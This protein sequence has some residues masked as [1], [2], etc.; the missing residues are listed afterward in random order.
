MTVPPLTT[1]T[2]T[3]TT[4]T[5]L[6]PENVQLDIAVTS[7]STVEVT[8]TSNPAEDILYYC[9]SFQGD[10]LKDEYTVFD[11]CTINGSKTISKSFQFEQDGLSAGTVYSAA[12]TIVSTH[13]AG[14]TLGEIQFTMPIEP[15]QCIGVLAADPDDA[16]NVFSEGDTITIVFDKP[17]NGA[18]LSPKEILDTF[19]TFSDSIG[20]DYSAEWSEDQ[21]ELVVTVHDASSATPLIGLVMVTLDGIVADVRDS[22]GVSAP[23]VT[24]S[25]PPLSGTWGEAPLDFPPKMTIAAVQSVEEDAAVE[26]M[27]RFTE[28]GITFELPT[29]LRLTA[30]TRGGNSNALGIDYPNPM[31]VKPLAGAIASAFALDSSYPEPDFEGS[32]AVECSLIVAETGDVLERVAIVIQVI[33]VNDVPTIDLA[34]RDYSILSNGAFQSMFTRDL[35]G[36]IIGD[37]DRDDIVDVRVRTDASNVFIMFAAS[38]DLEE[39]I[40]FDSSASNEVQVRGLLTDVNTRLWGLHVAASSLDPIDL[41]II[42]ADSNGAETFDVITIVPLCDPSHSSSIASAK[43]HSSLFG[44][45]VIFDSTVYVADGMPY[46]T[47]AT[48]FNNE[49]SASFGNHAVCTIAQFTTAITTSGNEQIQPL[50]GFVKV[51]VAF[52]SASTI[53]PSAIVATRSNSAILGCSGNAVNEMAAQTTLPPGPD[54]IQPALS[55]RSKTTSVGLCDDVVIS[56]TARG[57]G[58]WPAEYEWTEPSNQLFSSLSLPLPAGQASVSIPKGMW[59]QTE[60][61]YTVCVVARAAYTNLESAP[62]C[63][64]LSTSV[65]AVPKMM[66]PS[67]P[68]A[69]SASCKDHSFSLIVPHSAC[70]D[71]TASLD[72]VWVIHAVD[73]DTGIAVLDA[74]AVSGPWEAA[75]NPK[76]TV[77]LEDLRAS[78]LGLQQEYLATLTVS[79][80]DSPLSTSVQIRVHITCDPSIM[81][82]GGSEQQRSK[83]RPIKLISVVSDEYVPSSASTFRWSCTTSKGSVCLGSDFNPISLPTTSD[84]ELE[85]GYIDLGEYIF[86]VCANEDIG[87]A[88]CATVLIVVVPDCLE[89]ELAVTYQGQL[90]SQVPAHAT[91]SF[92]S[93]VNGAD[94]GEDAEPLIFEWSLGVPATVYRGTANMANSKNAP[95]LQSGT[96]KK[97]TVEAHQY[98]PALGKNVSGKAVAIVESPP[99]PSGGTVNLISK[100]QII[101]SGWDGGDGDIMYKCFYLVGD[102]GMH[103]NVDDRIY[104]TLGK[105]LSPLFTADFLPSGSITIGVTASNA[106]GESD[107]TV[108]VVNPENPNLAAELAA[109]KQATLDEAQKSGNVMPP[110]QLFSTFSST[111]SVV[112]DGGAET[113][114]AGRRARRAADYDDSESMM[115][116]SMWFNYNNL[117]SMGYEPTL[118]SQYQSMRSLKDAYSVTRWETRTAAFE[119]STGIM[120]ELLNNELAPP[121]T[122][123]LAQSMMTL[124]LPLEYVVLMTGSDG[125]SGGQD[126]DYAESI[127]NL[128]GSVAKA[129]ITGPDRPASVGTQIRLSNQETHDDFSIAIALLNIDGLFGYEED[130]HVKAAAAGKYVAVL[131]LLETCPLVIALGVPILNSGGGV[132]VHASP[133]VLFESY[134]S[135]GG[136][137]VPS[138]DLFSIEFQLE[139]VAEVGQNSRIICATFVEGKWTTDE[140]ETSVDSDGLVGN[141]TLP[142]GRGAGSVIVAV[143]EDISVDKVATSDGDDDPFVTTINTNSK[144]NHNVGGGGGEDDNN[145]DSDG[146]STGDSPGKG[147]LDL[148]AEEKVP[149]D[150]TVPTNTT[151]SISWWLFFITILSSCLGGGLLVTLVTKWVAHK[152]QKKAQADIVLIKKGAAFDDSPDDDGPEGRRK[153]R[154]MGMPSMK[155]GVYNGTFKKWFVLNISHMRGGFSNGVVF[156]HKR[157]FHLVRL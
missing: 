99:V 94:E 120:N 131:V 13:G 25:C 96:S 89:M 66:S 42:V 41:Y 31:S 46:V 87:R 44:L 113:P 73:A 75:T 56:V 59:P 15:P 130:V 62:A 51:N 17:T 110:F 147:I 67:V 71:P 118:Q 133:I 134:D 127:V 60:A 81:I 8:I 58:P 132:L 39:A 37:V 70:D 27:V 100:T 12:A 78:E 102:V 83:A 48:L 77:R 128:A 123:E 150:G 65:A 144:G 29:I 63:I 153:E 33:P 157:A 104:L 138:S 106:Y 6:P 142:A 38:G 40:E 117:D 18:N 11:A 1:S 145:I 50:L 30:L 14:T 74:A 136:V 126:R 115:V 80:R 86:A 90:V 22:F 121:V 35:D 82:M 64:E 10:H 23:V 92:V 20:N 154:P 116:D 101:T 84:F 47:C 24:D 49:T 97:F 53:T 2:T 57:A 112:T 5:V 16:D 139:L 137:I 32:F 107:A 68:S 26:V 55:M 155:K 95:V 141:C 125:E 152:A 151:V 156:R 119:T 43:F 7:P 69:V 108:H 93:N 61:N 34:A 124:I 3:T 148:G 28:E 85:A 140:V 111:L 9:F 109:Q 103:H 143:F 149:Y 36:N 19:I 88:T 122:V 114:A 54:L 72:Y 129:A 98:V 146:G 4:T 21:T 79:V 45:T 91:L 76:L 52:G 135:N 105:T